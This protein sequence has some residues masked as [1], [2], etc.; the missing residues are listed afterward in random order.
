MLSLFPSLLS[1]SQLSPFLIRL[2]LGVVLL[3]QAYKDMK[4]RGA[5]GNKKILGAIEAIVGIL[6]VIGLWTQLAALIA[7]LDL[8]VRLFFKAKSRAFLTDGVNY[9]LI[10]LVLALSLL[11]TGAGL[12]AFDLA[13]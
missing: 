6:L 13:L 5:T 10:L 11:F 1:W 9:Y 7:A 12:F 2:V 8:V 4:S 3:Y